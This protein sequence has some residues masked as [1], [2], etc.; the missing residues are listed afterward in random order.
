LSTTVLRPLRVK[1]PFR[2]S[3]RH[4]MAAMSEPAIS[5]VRPKPSGMRSFAVMAKRECFTA[6][7]PAIFTNSTQWVVVRIEGITG[8]YPYPSSS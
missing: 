6:S 3:A 1:P 8:R 7:A 5:S 2:L 4:W